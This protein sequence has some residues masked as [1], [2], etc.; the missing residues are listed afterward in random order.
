MINEISNGSGAGS[1]PQHCLQAQHVADCR[2]GVDLESNGTLLGHSHPS[3]GSEGTTKGPSSPHTPS[4]QAI[5]DGVDAD[6]A[7]SD[8]EYEEDS[9]EFKLGAIYQL[10]EGK[11]LCFAVHRDDEETLRDIKRFPRLFFFSSDLQV[12]SRCTHTQPRSPSPKAWCK[13]R[14]SGLL[15]FCA[16]SGNMEA[17]PG[18]A[19]PSARVCTCGRER[20]HTTGE[21]D[22]VTRMLWPKSADGTTKSHVKWG[23]RNAPF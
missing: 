5:P 23:V 18:F 13:G 15:L 19:P 3:E 6:A 21:S 2:G 14:F 16:F 20:T 17:L 9:V 11:R 12:M 1:A 7:R 10:I 4:V 8:D 22:D